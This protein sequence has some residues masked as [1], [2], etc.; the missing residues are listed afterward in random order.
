VNEENC[1]RLRKLIILEVWK[2]FLAALRVLSDMRVMMDAKDEF[3]RSFMMDEEDDVMI[4]GAAAKATKQVEESLANENHTL[5][6]NQSITLSDGSSSLQLSDTG[7]G[8]QLVNGLDGRD[9]EKGD[10]KDD[11]DAD[12]ELSDDDLTEA[13]ATDSASQGT[14]STA[15]CSDDTYQNR[16]FSGW[17]MTGTRSCCLRFGR[18]LGFWLLV[19]GAIIVGKE[20]VQ[21][22]SQRE[23]EQMEEEVRK[24]NTKH[25]R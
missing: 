16:K 6:T 24:R 13:S 11:E 3:H 17:D 8:G 18:F 15:T 2:R 5:K 25:R 14:T 22:A 9:E 20:M 19:A 1:S 4:A 21:Y 10:Q 7:E 23:A 12:D